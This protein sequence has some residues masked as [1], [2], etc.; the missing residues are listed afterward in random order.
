MLCKTHRQWGETSS[1]FLGSSVSKKGLACV[2]GVVVDNSAD[3]SS[4]FG[5]HGSL[6]TMAN[7]GSNNFELLVLVQNA[8]DP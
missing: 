1:L 6:S 7:D 8:F 3:F 4:K 2:S 5:R